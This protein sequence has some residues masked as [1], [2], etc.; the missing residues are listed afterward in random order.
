MLPLLQSSTVATCP[1]L[2]CPIVVGDF[3][4]AAGNSSSHGHADISVLVAAIFHSSNGPL[5]LAARRYTCLMGLWTAGP[6]VTSLS[7]YKNMAMSSPCIPNPPPQSLSS[8]RLP[9]PSQ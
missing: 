4:S 8:L 7:E 3:T 1:V 9:P 5:M 6:S 2:L